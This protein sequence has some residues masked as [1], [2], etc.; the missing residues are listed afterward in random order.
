MTAEIKVNFDQHLQVW[1][2]FGCNYVEMSHSRAG[3]Y[4]DY[5]SFSEMSDANKEK[6][7]DLTFGADGLQPSVIKMF[8]SSHLLQDPPQP[9]VIDLD[10]YRF[11]ECMAQTIYFAKEGI[12]RSREQGITLRFMITMYGPPA[13]GNQQKIIR[14]KDLDPAMRDS[15]AT[16]LAGCALY[17]RE[18]EGIPV[19]AISLHNEGEDPNRYPGRPGDDFN[20]YWKPDQIADMIARLRQQL[21][22]AG[23]SAVATAPG[24]TTLWSRFEPYAWAIASNPEARSGIGLITSHGFG[25]DF[26]TQGIRH[27]HEFRPELKVWTTSCSWYKSG[28]VDFA[29]NYVDQ[30]NQ[31]GVNALIP[32]ALIQTPPKW[33]GGDPNPNPPFL[34]TDD[35]QVEVNKSYYYYKQFT[36]AGQ[37]GMTVAEISGDYYN[38]LYALAFTSGSSQA[39]KAFLI[40]N[41][42]DKP[43]DVRL[44]VAGSSGQFELYRTDAGAKSYQHIGGIDFAVSG[45]YTAPPASVSTFFE[46][47]KVHDH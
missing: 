34:I 15:L 17:L 31:I 27:L 5:G 4:E 47:G 6:I 37:P 42:A 43:H 25:G 13:W 40:V 18:R 46:G 3:A 35:R 38:S 32:W 8:L 26:G 23:L 24:E 20:M 33:P 1:D 44:T 19:E 36:Q 10:K 45:I 22:A 12:R 7:L 2:G 11:N 39:P 16:F 14:G 9:G 29:R 30:I 21:D 41:A 28:G